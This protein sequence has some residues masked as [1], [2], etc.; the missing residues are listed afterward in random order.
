[1][2]NGW[3]YGIFKRERESDNN[4][5]IIIITERE[6]EREVRWFCKIGVNVCVWW[7]LELKG[8]ENTKEIKNNLKGD[9]YD[10]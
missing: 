3:I 7:E 1:M 8:E 2:R 10:D 4:N 9:E 5:N 6:R